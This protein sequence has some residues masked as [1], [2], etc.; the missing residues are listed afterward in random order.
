VK[1]K[2]PSEA[3]TKSEQKSKPFQEEK[4]QKPKPSF[5]DCVHR[6]AQLS[7]F[8]RKRRSIIRWQHRLNRERP[9]CT[10]RMESLLKSANGSMATV[11]KLG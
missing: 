10:E 5:G 8:H 4:R 9:T 7:E 2:T 11:A 6:Q 1:N 3:K